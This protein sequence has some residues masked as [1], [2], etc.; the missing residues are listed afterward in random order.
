[1]APTAI[2]AGEGVTASEVKTADV[3]F[4]EV[5]ALIVP[6]LA[7]I[8]VLPF[9]IPVAKP[10]AV[11]VATVFAEEVQVAVPVRSWLLPSLY[12]P[13]AVNCCVM[14][15]AMEGA[16]GVREIE[17]NV[18]PVTV[19]AVDPL[20]VPEVAVIVVVPAVAPVANPPLP[21][22]ATEVADEVQIDVVVRFLVVPLLYVPVAVNCSVL[23]AAIEGEAGA[24]AIDVSVAAVT[25]KALEPVIVPEAALIVDIPA[26]TPVARPVFFTVATEAVDDVHLAVLVNSWVLPLL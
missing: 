10:A 15:R 24:M 14:P 1:V 11:T 19:S 23:P 13:V 4:R 26:E 16:A 6:D 7:V 9:A 2:V 5:E 12:L 3:T 25:V 20:I 21:M 18:A 22:A 17:L 8:V